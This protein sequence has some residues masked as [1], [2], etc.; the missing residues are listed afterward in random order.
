MEDESGLGSQNLGDERVI[1]VVEGFDLK[2]VTIG[3]QMVRRF[4][5]NLM[6]CFDE[7]K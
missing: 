3:K 7:G 1:E 6:H 2:V 4:V 5:R